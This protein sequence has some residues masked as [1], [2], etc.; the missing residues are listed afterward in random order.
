MTDIVSTEGVLGG[1]PRIEGWRIGVH[2][3]AKRVIDA[4]QA[5]ERVAAE[6]DLDVADIQRALAYYDDHPGEMRAAQAARRTVP[7]VLRVVRGP[8]DLESTNEPEPEA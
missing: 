6:H 4:G 1:A 7:D 8:D 2:H 3:V 5:P